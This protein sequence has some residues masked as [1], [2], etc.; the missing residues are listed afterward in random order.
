MAVTLKLLVPVNVPLDVVTSTAPEVA[1]G[2]TSATRALVDWLTGTAGTLPMLIDCV[3]EKSVP[4]TVISVPTGP[5]DGENEIVTA[6]FEAEPPP[7][8]LSRKIIT[9]AKQPNTEAAFDLIPFIAPPI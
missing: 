7:Q 4:V 6:D 3:V 2:M 1:P 5:E 9:K 8:P